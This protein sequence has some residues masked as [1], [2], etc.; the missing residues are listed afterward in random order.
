LAAKLVASGTNLIAS[1]GQDLRIYD[2]SD[3]TAVDEL[4]RM[5]LQGLP[6]IEMA[7]Q[8]QLVYLGD[9]TGLRIIDFTDSSRP[10]Q[11]GFAPMPEGTGGVAVSGTLAYVSTANG[12]LV[13]LD[14][15]DPSAPLELARCHAY[16]MGGPVRV[17]DGIAYV[18]GQDGGLALVDVSDPTQP[19][20]EARSPRAVFSSFAP[21]LEIAP[22]YAFV[23]EG[24]RGVGVFE[25]SGCGPRGPFRRI[26]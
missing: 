3:P 12:E 6:S 23:V 15:S 24:E 19:R 14:V 9:T 8:G 20:P 5:N 17:A 21:D 7:A 25:T 26:R 13:V 22:P 11:I 16:H 10:R 2:A 18:S 4:G 1:D